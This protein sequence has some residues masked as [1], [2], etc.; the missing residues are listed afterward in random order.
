MNHL[1][2]PDDSPISIDTNDFEQRSGYIE[3]VNAPL[4]RY[5]HVLK[6][7]TTTRYTTQTKRRAIANCLCLYPGGDNDTSGSNSNDDDDADD[8]GNRCHTLLALGIRRRET[9][10]GW[11]TSFV[12]TEG[13]KH[14]TKCHPESDIA[15]EANSRLASRR[16]DKLEACNVA[17]TLAGDATG[18]H[19]QKKQT[20]IS[21]SISL[22]VICLASQSRFFLYCTSDV[23]KNLFRDAHYKR[24]MQVQWEAGVEAGV[25]KERNKKGSAKKMTH[26]QKDEMPAPVLDHRALEEYT[27]CEHAIFQHFLVQIFKRGIEVHKGN[28]FLITLHDGV[29]V[30]GLKF[31]SNAVQFTITHRFLSEEQ[32]LEVK[33]FWFNVFCNIAFIREH[34]HEMYDNDASVTAGSAKNLAALWRTNVEQEY[35]HEQLGGVSLLDLSAATVCD[36]AV[37]RVSTYYDPDP[38]NTNESTR[39]EMHNMD[40]VAQSAFSDLHIWR[41]KVQ[42]DPIPLVDDH[43]ARLKK[44]ST[45]YSYGSRLENAQKDADDKNVKHC[46]AMFKEAVN[47]TRIARVTQQIKKMLRAVL[48]LKLDASTVGVNHDALDGRG[49]TADEWIATGELYGLGALMAQYTQLVQTEQHFISG[50]PLVF[51]VT[52]KELLFRGELHVIDVENIKDGSDTLPFVWRDVGDLSAVCQQA[53][54]QA[55]KTFLVSIFLV[56]LVFSFFFS[57]LVFLIQL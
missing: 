51:R 9:R 22:P 42:Q 12:T 27:R 17:G 6:D 50:V 48:M 44:M 24:M 49:L 5:V 52:L 15:Q 20:V 11:T 13:I 16:V 40:P 25:A 39:C 41:K 18:K 34:L 45:F 30:N 23:K 31:Q 38:E 19:L 36:G 35:S 3:G 56:F 8:D 1:E 28:K 32:Q 2:S 46:K 14:F 10:K 47:G 26:S 4:W 57:F 29:T 21:S 54:Q 55:Q 53:L 43:M 33:P 37:L 7:G